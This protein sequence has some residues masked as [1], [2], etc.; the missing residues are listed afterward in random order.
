MISVRSIAI[1][2]V[3]FATH[4]VAG[5][6]PDAPA[7][8]LPV[9]DGANLRFI[10]LPLGV[11]PSHRRITGIVQDDLGFL[12]IGTD[13]GL[14]RYDGYR[15]R[16]YRHDPKD[17]N[18]LP[19]SYIVAL[20]KDRSGKL[21]VASG[22]NLDIYDPATEKFTAFRADRNS[23]K[24]WT[25]RVAGISQDRGGTIWLST[26]KGLYE[27]DPAATVRYYYRHDAHNVDSLSSNVVRSAIESRDGTV[28]VATSESVESIDRKSHKVSKR[29]AFD[30]AHSVEAK[31]LEDHAGV[32]WLVYGGAR[33]PG[34]AIVDRTANVLTHYNFI[35]I[36]EKTS[37]G[38]A[39]I[40]EDADS[41]LWL[42]TKAGGLYKLD[43]GRTRY[44]R[45]RNNPTD[46]T[47]IASDEISMLFEDREGS[48]WVGTHGD[49][50]DR[51][52]RKPLPFRRYVHEPGN[53]NSLDKD[54]VTSVF[55]D[56]R[57]VLWI[58]CSRSLVRVDPDTSK[59]EFFRTHGT[60]RLGG[61][62]T[63]MHVISM[64][65]D[66]SGD[67]WFGT[68]GGGL[69]R[70]DRG[71]GWAQVFRYD[72][73]NPTGL[74]NDIVKSLHF[75]HAGVLWAGTDDGL[76]AFD[77]KTQTF[78][79]YPP[80]VKPSAYRWIA[81]D[82]HGG[83]WLS[84]GWSGVHR[85]DPASAKF[86]VYRHSDAQGSLSSDAV[87][88]VCVDHSGIVWVGTQ[89]GLNRLDPATGMA[90]VY[91]PGPSTISVDSILEDSK[92]NLW[93]GTE[94]GLVQFDPRA[95]TFRHYYTSD[96]L[97]AN[98]LGFSAAWKSPQGEM[99]FGSYGGLT[100]FD[101]ARMVEDSYEPPV[102]LTDIQ[103][104]GK[105]VAIGGKSPL[106]QSI[107]M[108]NS[109]GLRYTQNTFS[110]EFSALTF[111]DPA[112]NRYRYRLEPLEKEWNEVDSSRRSL[113][114]VAL[115]AGDYVLR[116]L[117][118]NGR[119]IWNEA[120]VRLAISVSP[121][122]WSSWWFRTVVAGLILFSAWAFFQIRLRQQAHE[123]SLRLDERVEERT[124]IA[125][126][127]HD[128]LLQSF[129]GALFQMQAA[130]NL[131]SRRPEQAVQTLDEAITIS[132]NAVAEGRNA[133]RDLRPKACSP[134]ELPRLLTAAG[135]ECARSREDSGHRVMFRVT[136]EGQP[137]QLDPLVLD[138]IYQ[139]SRELLRNAFQ[140]AQASQIEAELRYE[141]Q[142]LRVCIR[143]DGKG[144]DPAI[145]KAGGRDG[146]WGLPGAHERAS[147]IGARL[148]YWTEA[149]SG[150]EVS[151]TIPTLIGNGG[152]LP[153]RR[154]RMFRKG[155]T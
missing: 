114:Y 65:D 7:I 153:R 8:T 15:I 48:V 33:G 96:G 45:Y 66:R 1:I 135:E 119:G 21:W 149:G 67:L 113:T 11:D 77:P 87:N 3:L 43:P 134:S 28:W 128:T 97:A 63:S 117:G 24:R 40:H 76:D 142:G 126:E 104:L 25:G 138:E 9:A 107:S 41:N 49:G 140:H 103:I 52:T 99:Y 2:A 111:A 6:K 54:S 83:L 57:G 144:I 82:S 60:A 42:G 72:K 122:W 130:R 95:K 70:L 152:T 30:M 110:L 5:T 108:T 34:L 75:D 46:Q 64:A 37:P 79:V 71:T 89:A 94:N 26:D 133:I 137:Q 58:G 116:V 93:L 101:P 86:T 69:N 59:F 32:L 62:S 124:R 143:D 14:K 139:I 91:N 53:P 145:V 12:W 118:S 81:E 27:V 20:F 31:I 56:S 68:Q 18:S 141:G 109:L 73:N 112:R 150:T 39:C 131:L 115:P 13:D 50:I 136:V 47:S 44:V 92:G 55:R 16:D 61:M 125:R 17:P 123:L 151:L 29:A 38:V 80:P 146:H 132:E 85:F 147:R 23:Q 35:P 98:E 78:H 127:L 36:D 88:A 129:Q 120:G 106:Q 100:V 148:D 154:F 90:T 4:L 51:F 121:P 22:R 10:H 155:T 102:R 84:T 105:P 19:D 74:S